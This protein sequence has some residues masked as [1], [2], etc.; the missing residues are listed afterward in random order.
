MLQRHHTRTRKTPFPIIM[1]MAMPIGSLS[2]WLAIFSLLS[3]SFGLSATPVQ[4]GGIPTAPA[5]ELR[6]IGD[7]SSSG[8]EIVAYDSSTQRVFVTTGSTVEIIGVSDPVNP[9][10]IDSINVTSLGAS[11][12]SVDVAESIVAVAIA[13]DPQTDPGT[14]AFYDTDGNLQNSVTVGALPDMLTFTPDGQTVLVANEGEPDGGIDPEGSI[15]II[16]VSGGVASATVTTA[17]FTAFNGQE[18][19][20]RSEGVRIFPGI[21]AANDFEPEYITTPDGVTAYIALQENNAL[22]VLDIATQA[23][24]DV[25]PL[26]AKDHNIAGNGLDASDQDSGINIQTWPVF[27]LYMPDAIASY[28][29]GAADYIFTANEGDARSEDDRIADLDLDDTAF[30]NE[31]SLK[32][33]AQLG[34]LE[35]S[36]IDGDTD[37][38]NDYDQLFAYGARS[39]SIFDENGNLVYDSGDDL[40]Q[41]VAAQAPSLFN[42][43]GDAGSFDGRSDN[44]GPEP[45]GLALGTIGSNRILFLG[46]ERDSGI[47]LF[48]VTNPNA[49]N[50]LSYNRGDLNDVS[51]EGLL[52]IDAGSSPNGN[53]LL[54]VA[55]EESNTIVVYE[56]VE[57][58]ALPVV[59]ELV[60]NEFAPKGT[61]QVELYNTTGDE[62][63]LSGVYL[64]DA[65]CGA[66][67][68][69]LAGGTTIAA[70]GYFVVNA[71]DAGDNFSLDNSGDVLILCDSN[72]TELDRVGYGDEGGAPL[73]PTDIS[74][75]RVSDGADTDDDANDF[76]LDTT[77]TFGS[78]NDPA[79]VNLGAG[80]FV[81][82]EVDPGDSDSV[83]LYQNVPD[84][85][86]SLDASSASATGYFISD[87][88]SYIELTG[89]LEPN[90]DG[91]IVLPTDPYFP[92]GGIGFSD[93]IYLFAPDGSRIDQL[94]YSGSTFINDCIA[95]VPDGAG[96]NDSFSDA[97][98]DDPAIVDQACTLG[99]SNS[100][101]PT[102]DLFIN[103]VLFN[104]PG[105]DAPNE[106]IELRGAPN[107]T[108]PTG[109][110][111]VNIEG[112]D[113]DPGDINS[114]IDLSGQTLG[115]NGYLVVVESGNPYAIDSN[116]AVFTTNDVRQEN[117]SNTFLLIESST[118]PSNDDDID[119]DDDGTPDGAIFSNWTVLDGIAFLDD[120]DT[121]EYAYTTLVYA[122]DPTRVN[123]PAGAEII[124][125]DGAA[126]YGGRQGDSTGGTSS[127]WVAGGLAGSPP[128]LVLEAGDTYPASL[129][130]AALDHIGSFNEY[131]VPSGTTVTI[132]QIQGTGAAFSDEFYRSPL[133]GDPVTTSGIVTALTSDGFFLQDPD[134]DGDDASSDGIF[135]FLGSAPTVNVGDAIDISAT[136]NERFEQTVLQNVTDITT[137][138]T[139]SITPLILGTDRTPPTDIVDDAGS[140]T[141]DIANHG[142]DFWESLEGMLVTLPDAIVISPYRQF[143]DGPDADRE[144]YALA[145]QGTGATGLVASNGGIAVRPSSNPDNPAGIDY[146]PERIQLDGNPSTISAVKVGD[147]LGDVTGP[148]NY[149]FNDYA[150][151]LTQALSVTD[152]GL[153]PEVTTLQEAQDR[154]T[155]ASY[156]VLN[157]DPGDGQARFDALAQ[158]IVVNLN[159]PDI[160]GLQ[161][162]QDNNGPD[163]GG[164]SADQTL[165]ALVDAITAAG[166]PS[167]Q[168]I[169]NTFIGNNTNGG[170]PEGNIRVAFL[171]DPTRVSL[172]PDSVRP[173]TDPTDQQTN[174]SNPF[175]DSRLPLAA[176][177]DF[178]GT[179]LTI[180][181]NHFSSRGGSDPV[182]GEDQPPAIGSEAAREAQ[183][184]AIN[185]FVDSILSDNP[186]ANVFVIGDLNGF[187]F[188]NFIQ[189]TL[190]G[191]VLNIATPPPIVGYTFNFEGNS[192]ALDHI[193]YTPNDNI[194]AIGVDAVNINADFDQDSRASDHDPIMIAVTLP[195]VPIV[196]GTKQADVS[197]NDDGSYTVV[198]SIGVE[199]LS[200]FGV[201]G[202]QISDGLTQFYQRTDL[203]PA[204]VSVTGEGTLLA[205][206]D[207]DGLN[208]TLLLDENAA[209]ELAANGNATITLTIANFN[210][211]Q[212][213]TA[214]EN[215]AMLGAEGGP[216]DFS[217]DGDSA[218]PNANGNPNEAGENDPTVI[219]FNEQPGGNVPTI[220]LLKRGEVLPS[221][222]QNGDGIANPGDVIEYTI[223]VRNTSDVP[224]VDVELNDLLDINTTFANFFP[225]DSPNVT[226]T[227]GDPFVIN[228]DTLP[229]GAEE[230]V[231]FTVNVIAGKSLGPT[232]FISNS[233]SGTAANIPDFF[234]S[235]DPTTPEVGDAVQIPYEVGQPSLDLTKRDTLQ[236]DANGNGQFDI[237]DTIRYTLV[238]QNI[239]TAIATNITLEDI[240]DSGVD[241]IA[242]SLT[243][244][245]GDPAQPDAQLTID[246]ANGR[247]GF[248]TPELTPGQS[249]TMTFDVLINASAVDQIANQ[250]FAESDNGLSIGSDDPDTTLFRDATISTLAGTARVT[251]FKRASIISGGVELD[252]RPV[253]PGGR[254]QYSVSIENSG[255]APVTN[256]I[257][258]DA[259]DDFN[260]DLEAGT[261]ITSLGTVTEGNGPSDLS[262][263]VTIAEI[264]AGQT[265]TISFIGRVEEPVDASADF[266]E[267][268]GFITYEGLEGDPIPTGDPTREG[269]GQPTRVDIAGRLGNLTKTADYTE[270]VGP[271]DTITYTI[272]GQNTS[273]PD[274]PINLNDPLGDPNL[275]L[276]PDSVT[277]LIE[278]ADVTDDVDI[279]T[280]DGLTIFMNFEQ[281][282]AEAQTFTVTFEATVSDPIV[283]D[284]S[285]TSNQAIVNGIPTDDPTTPTEGDPTLVP[286]S[287]ASV[288]A[289]DKTAEFSDPLT[290]GDG[291]TYTL[292]VSNNSASDA[293]NV[294]LEDLLTDPNL[295]AI[296]AGDV[297][298]NSSGS[299]TTS[300]E[301]ND[302]PDGGQQV[303]VLLDVLEANATLTVTIS[304]TISDPLND[305]A[306]R[307]IANEATARADNAARTAPASTASPIGSATA[308]EVS[309]DD[310][311]IPQ[312]SY[313]LAAGATLGEVL[314]DNPAQAR[315]GDYIE[316]S[317][318]I[319]NVGDNPATD[320]TFTDAVANPNLTL[321]TGSVVVNDPAATIDTGNT[322]GDTTV[323]VSIPSVAVD[324]SVTI[325]YAVQVAATLPSGLPSVASQADVTGATVVETLSDDPATF[326]DDDPTQTPL[327]NAEQ[328]ELAIRKFAPSETQPGNQMLYRIEVTNPNETGVARDLVVTDELPDTL[329][330]VESVDGRC[331]ATGQTVTCTTLALDAGSRISFSFVVQVAPDAAI[332]ST[333]V[334]EATLTQGDAGGDGDVNIPI[335]VDAPAVNLTAPITSEPVQTLVVGTATQS[336]LSVT[337]DDGR[338]A[339]V[340]GNTAANSTTT[341]YEIVVRNF[342]ADV[343]DAGLTL[344]TNQNYWVAGSFDLQCTPAGGASCPTPLSPDLGTLVAVGLGGAD[345]PNGGSVSFELTLQIVPVNDLPDP[346]P[347]AV[348]V[349]VNH[350]SD[351]DSL[352]GNNAAADID[353][354]VYDP[355]TG[356]KSGTLSNG[357]T[358]ITWV[359]NWRNDTAIAATGVTISD[360]LPSNQSYINGTL[361]C[362]FNGPN[363]FGTCAES[364]GE[365]TFTGQIGAN[366]SIDITFDV[367]ISGTGSFENIS[368]LTTNNSTAASVQASDAVA[369]QPPPPILDP[370]GTVTDSGDSAAPVVLSKLASPAFAQPGE[371]ITFTITVTNPNSSALAVTASDTLPNG[372]TLIGASLS[373]GP[374]TVS[375]SGNSVSYDGTLAGNASASISVN[376]QISSSVN[377]PFAL[378]NVVTSGDIS[379]SATVVS[380]TELPATGETPWWRLPLLLG[381]GLLLLIAGGFVGLLLRRR[382]A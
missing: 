88:D 149:D 346:G 117:A 329:T 255:N 30:P 170:Q 203:D 11:A 180:I 251:A 368:V 76:N 307:F 5:Y 158:D 286:L 299:G 224:A 86:L 219:T 140:S 312:E 183:A 41:T 335:G 62:L 288:L 181:N 22:A 378:T 68:S 35:V 6:R 191:G 34:R 272:S 222:D 244:T 139:G 366:E 303:R 37:N 96:P 342:G 274:L 238:L 36:T 16:D 78:S 223:T 353:A 109:T 321:V 372:L 277:V 195:Q 116:A 176:D 357:D 348:E 337:I 235:D 217:D 159:A 143:G 262:V 111:L 250:A 95:R 290:A 226:I 137:T 113:N 74:I 45:E 69:T 138:G 264:P 97:S 373:S 358:V 54:V 65:A 352:G 120:D 17:T 10:S 380:V 354:I 282:L 370:G 240:L 154:V 14:V 185:D 4:A 93:V 91:M 260:L 216:M 82:N 53:P 153:T 305:E 210:L 164:T 377:V 266:I 119:S 281:A 328:A 157:L 365:I 102:S 162:I 103:E 60:I 142:R 182:F 283:G 132:M 100:T 311:I 304:A 124:D 256:V 174:P 58:S 287:G 278:G 144:I 367:A 104:P 330:F 202:I 188:E 295:N 199:N 230:T 13:A 218:D 265:V 293:L 55:Y 246:G 85:V 44:K 261:V 350:P 291:I 83:E 310:T 332:G 208:D 271:G 273:A 47:S 171:Y 27:G 39:F 79:G 110:Y 340:S 225:P 184:Q 70:N 127:D 108:I 259:M 134:G 382:T 308:V 77:P 345:L 48:D 324:G 40:E 194:S 257:F 167:Y 197:V 28:Q 166:G 215:I 376:A 169:D 18:A 59:G 21:S 198:Y 318:T 12:T 234:F 177:F 356:T 248:T 160:I 269:G 50:Y 29:I 371:A 247:V 121:N 339:L 128:D 112:D 323:A 56:V 187:R 296:T 105:G 80:P 123:A 25:L 243:V 179:P 363:T 57:P 249:Y 61:E 233:V 280:T 161:E 294:V 72:D 15:S 347:V 362:S 333:I 231:R 313:A 336:D 92:S 196:G 38:D 133:N 173:A 43:Q 126:N 63:D 165:Q 87:G 355:P 334:N 263:E 381:A 298:A 129:E 343:S 201:S 374:G 228:I 19:T 289:L 232:P 306:Q 52:F 178:N 131:V 344:F 64:D 192:Q 125:T 379:A 190:S 319:V 200:N 146:N 325:R 51:P 369:I 130:G 32:Q 1:A 118:A 316:Y 275:N 2:L 349:T 361:D 326:A 49:P 7:I 186:G 338:T 172:I 114:F 301:V 147:L 90:A 297:T 135:V 309:L 252:N 67:S 9:T 8:A 209:R 227:A 206:A 327:I 207:Y 253:L 175:F 101:E 122:E 193:L 302:L 211:R 156:N 375:T 168:L 98:F 239:G 155:I 24:T 270:P 205:N 360:L 106:Y 284:A 151:T 3:L 322:D 242:D 364:G 214:I 220:E 94:G 73:A 254:I 300:V 81:I 115:S 276:V 99:A 212:T 351:P 285:A 229:P 42:S 292:T 31:A 20:L 245:K 317:A 152:G 236:N 136:A 314:F 66:G 46:H 237:G 33:N 258:T 150:I 331:N 107:A 145:N 341:T 71:G 267:N 26:G 213:P 189:N 141:Y 241:Y 320:L 279:S 163:S 84:A 268:Q 75:A 204:N 89:S 221:Q 359:Q 315:P 148:I 23:I